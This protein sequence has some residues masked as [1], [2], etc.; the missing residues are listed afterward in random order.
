LKHGCLVADANAVNNV[1]LHALAA[2]HH[3]FSLHRTDATVCP[4]APGYPGLAGVTCGEP[5]PENY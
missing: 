1:K 3:S 4:L 2:S 5:M